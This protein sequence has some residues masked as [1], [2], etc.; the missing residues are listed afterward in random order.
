MLYV[1]TRGG[2]RVT[3]LEAVC[4]G[5]S[6]TGGLFTAENP[7]EPLKLADLRGLTFQQVMA[8]YYHGYIPDLTLG[9]WESLVEQAFASLT[10][11]EDTAALPLAKLNPYLDRYYLINTDYFPT[12]SMADLT[13]AIL[14]GLFEWIQRQSG[15]LQPLVIGLGS[16]DLALAFWGS[17][18]GAPKLLLVPDPPLRAG[19]LLGQLKPGQE[20]RVFSEELGSRYRELTDLAGDLAFEADLRSR[21]LAPLFLTPGHLAAVLT[22]GALATASVAHILETDDENCR[23]DFVV[24]KGHLSFL[25]GLVDASSL[26]IPVGV[27]YIG[28]SE[29]PSLTTLF[30]SGRIPLEDKN[31]RHPGSGA[32]FPVNLERLLFEVTGRDEKRIRALMEELTNPQGAPLRDEEIQLL[33]QSIVVAACDYKYGLQLMRTVYDQTD[34]LF[35]RDTADALAAWSRNSRK[36]DTNPVCFVQLRSPLLD[37]LASYRAVFGQKDLTGQ[38]A[39]AVLIEET[40]VPAWPGLLETGRKEEAAPLPLLQGPIRQTIDSFL[41]ACGPEV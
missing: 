34:Y 3:A 26:G 37:P 16:W 18:A 1:S 29:P 22:A 5:L 19:E 12:G 28:E 4:R 25:A 33:N 31:R 39:L 27:A 40:G 2:E 36:R 21:G 15:G 7:P 38:E 23:V 11:E 41:A 14:S 17:L 9:E 8:R 30:K 35:G 24:P 13:A 20:V 10:P 32:A 6:V